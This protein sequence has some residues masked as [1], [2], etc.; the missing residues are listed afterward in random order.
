MAKTVEWKN[1][2][3][4]HWWQ[5]EHSNKYGRYESKYINN[6]FKHYYLKTLIKRDY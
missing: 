6:Q 3:K 2:Y 4:E 5:I 1:R